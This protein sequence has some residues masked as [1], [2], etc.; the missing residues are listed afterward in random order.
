MNKEQIK[1]LLCIASALL[2]VL[3][4]GLFIFGIVFDGTGFA[5]ALIFVA[6]VLVL[7]L[8]CEL[9]Y[10]FLL[11]R[12]VKPNYF[13]FN[14]SLN[15]NIPVE[16]LTFEVIDKR[17]NRYLSNFTD[18]ESKLWTD[19]VL[20]D[21]KIAID[22]AFKPLVAYKLLF[23]IANFDSEAGWKCF[24]LASGATIEFIARGVAQNGDTELARALVQLKSAK[25]V[26][27]KQTRDYLV[28][29]KKYLQKKLYKYVVENIALF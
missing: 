16:K 25:P 24:V 4:I 23:D 12:M 17:M 5:K 2:L 29:N 18:S 6:A 10:I 27:M 15:S 21:P 7:V 13:L 1:L 22:A 28:G 9:A 20:D 19:R 3:A 14:P 26:N 11:T 8:A